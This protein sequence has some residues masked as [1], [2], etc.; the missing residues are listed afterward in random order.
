MI[1]DLSI[2]SHQKISIDF[3]RDE[4]FVCHLMKKNQQ[5]LD[6]ENKGMVYHTGLDLKR[7]SP[8]RVM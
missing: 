7:L 8:D 1:L 4:T 3:Y 5:F 6:D 2:F